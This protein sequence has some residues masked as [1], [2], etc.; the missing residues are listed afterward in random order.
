MFLSAIDVILFSDTEKF[1]GRQPAIQHYNTFY[2]VCQELFNNFSLIMSYVVF[3]T[4]KCLLESNQLP[5]DLTSI[6]LPNELR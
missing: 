5:I 2:S 3:Y 1:L 4:R 6:A